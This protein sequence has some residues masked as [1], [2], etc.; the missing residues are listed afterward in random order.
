[1]QTGQRVYKDCREC[2]GSGVLH[3]R[4]NFAYPET[5]SSE[6]SVPVEC[7]YCVGEGILPWGYDMRNDNLFRSYVV[8]EELDA[9]EHN[10]LTDTQKNGVLHLLA[11]GIVDL[12]EGK[13]GR[14]R[15]WNW[16]GAESTTVANLTA[17]LV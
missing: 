16:F 9:T 15:L 4:P 12:N 5:H 14:V 7:H 13:A 1:M 8:L 2:R 6:S 11:C 10:A 17:L 3:K